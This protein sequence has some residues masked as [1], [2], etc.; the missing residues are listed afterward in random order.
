MG[1]WFGRST[2]M[3]KRLENAIEMMKNREDQDE[4]RKS[5]DAPSSPMRIKVR[6][7]KRQLQELKAHADMSEGNSDLG[8]LIVKEC[9]EGRLSPHV[10]VGQSHVSEDSTLKRLSLSTIDE[11]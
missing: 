6:M 10:V 3:V 2:L 11:E 1:N 9:L 5:F 8:R 7:T 4:R